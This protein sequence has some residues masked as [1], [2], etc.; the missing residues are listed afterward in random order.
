LSLPRSARGASAARVE[1]AVHAAIMMRACLPA[2]LLA[3]YAAFADAIIF[4]AM[5]LSPLFFTLIL[6]IFFAI[7]YCRCH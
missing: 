4:H 5:P 3:D 6:F 2:S 1:R 7:R